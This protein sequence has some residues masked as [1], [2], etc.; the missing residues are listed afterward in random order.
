MNW[1]NW[2]YNLTYIQ[3]TGDNKG[4]IVDVV[5]VPDIDS[6]TIFDI[7]RDIIAFGR[8]E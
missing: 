1:F 2:S 3:L 6:K 5:N 7:E 4:L 8:F